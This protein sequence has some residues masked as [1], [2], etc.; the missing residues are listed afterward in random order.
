M[1]T[2]AISSNELE[3]V[4]ELTAA[5]NATRQPGAKVAVEDAVIAAL[6]DLLHGR[7]LTSGDLSMATDATLEVNLE[8][9]TAENVSRH[10]NKVAMLSRR[11]DP[12][13]PAHHQPDAWV[14][15]ELAT[16]AGDWVDEELQD[17]A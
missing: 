10:A 17:E 14:D 2:I 9:A 7:G 16:E 12:T 13:I 8:A 6:I 4:R 5:M 3:H 11:R 15:E 1:A